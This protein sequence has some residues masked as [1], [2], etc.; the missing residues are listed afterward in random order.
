MIAEALILSALIMI[1]IAVT[2]MVFFQD[3]RIR[4]ALLAFIYL[5]EFLM[6]SASWPVVLAVSKLIAGWMACAIIGMALIGNPISPTNNGTPAMNENRHLA[7]FFRFD[8]AILFYFISAILVGLFAIS[9][10][11]AVRSWLPGIQ[12]EHLWIGLLLIGMGLLQ[13]SFRKEDFAVILGLLVILSGFEI[14]YVSV[15]QSILVTALLAAVTLSLALV[16]AY[17]ILAPQLEDE[18]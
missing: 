4:I 8:P 14:L 15:E 13:L 10:S 12:D 1:G 7:S 9:A 5:G 6:I 16:G 18:E 2:L 3:W 11:V 17:L